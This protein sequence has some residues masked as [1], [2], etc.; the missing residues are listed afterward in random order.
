MISLTSSNL[1]GAE[2]NGG[3]LYIEFRGGRIY[4][5]FAVPYSIFANRPTS[6]TRCGNSSG[7]SLLRQDRLKKCS[8]TESL[9]HTGGCIEW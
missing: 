1:A 3:S 5:Y 6:S 4:E 2:Y 7:R 9:Q 8:L